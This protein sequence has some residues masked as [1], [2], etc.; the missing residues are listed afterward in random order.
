MPRFRR[1]NRLDLHSQQ[2]HQ[3]NYI[4]VLL[5]A[6]SIGGA[7]PIGLGGF[8]GD[9]DLG[10]LGV[11]VIGLLIGIGSIWSLMNAERKYI[12]TLWNEIQK[13]PNQLLMELEAKGKH[14]TVIT[15]KGIFWKRKAFFDFRE[16]KSVEVRSSPNLHMAFIFEY[17]EA[18]RPFKRVFNIEAHQAKRAEEVCKILRE[19][20][21]SPQ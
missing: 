15:Q 16:M 12:D 20:Y 13:Q 2:K 11:L 5:A 21:L 10:F 1:K 17:G 8:L 9:W 3:T 4:L 18:G 6:L 7:V 14:K 19:E